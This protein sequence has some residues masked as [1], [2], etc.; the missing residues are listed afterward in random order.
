MET[1]NFLQLKIVECFI[2]AIDKGV[3]KLRETIK[4]SYKS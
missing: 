1:G 4:A 2:F 3:L